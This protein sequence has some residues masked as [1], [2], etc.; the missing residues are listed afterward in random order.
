MQA[1]DGQ[2]CGKRDDG[3][4]TAHGP[5][6][7]CRRRPREHRDPRDAL[8]DPDGTSRRS[9]RRGGGRGCGDR[10]GLADPDLHDE[11][12]AGAEQPCGIG[13]EPAHDV[14]AIGAGVEGRRRLVPGDVGRDVRAVVGHVGRVRHDDVDEPAR[15]RRR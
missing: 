11:T 8:R 10:V 2:T 9:R 14:Q 12:A 7:G 15:R 1:G 4:Q 13:D 5:F 6:I 3:E